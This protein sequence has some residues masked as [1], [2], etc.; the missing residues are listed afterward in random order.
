M[1]NNDAYDSDANKGGD[2]EKPKDGKSFAL[3]WSHSCFIEF[4]FYGLVFKQE[5]KKMLGHIRF[6]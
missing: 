4:V 6:E 2:F 3:P 1:S 5:E